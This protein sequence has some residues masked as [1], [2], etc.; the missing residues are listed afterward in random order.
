MIHHHKNC[1]KLLKH[2]KLLFISINKWVIMGVDHSVRPYSWLFMLNQSLK[3]VRTLPQL[4]LPDYDSTCRDTLIWVSQGI[5]D[6][7]LGSVD[8]VYPGNPFFS[9]EWIQ[10][11]GDKV[12]TG[13]YRRV[14]PEE[15]PGNRWWRNWICVGAITISLIKDYMSAPNFT[16]TLLSKVLLPSQDFC[17]KLLDYAQIQTS[18]NT[19]YFRQKYARWL[20][21]GTGTEMRRF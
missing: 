1:S 9:S 4:R 6:Q 14:K 3:L 19:G 21:L 17:A 2:H 13:E 11:I 10:R 15:L 8:Q 18:A 16:F 12:R 20:Q 7:G 5:D